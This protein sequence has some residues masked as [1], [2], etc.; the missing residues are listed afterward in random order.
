MEINITL[1]NTKEAPEVALV[2]DALEAVIRATDVGR[3]A[4]NIQDRIQQ[5]ANATAAGA[6]ETAPDQPDG[7]QI[8]YAE[9]SDVT[10]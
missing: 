2:V 1:Q 5:A 7:G 4:T 6:T 3:V 9:A 10:S 8:T